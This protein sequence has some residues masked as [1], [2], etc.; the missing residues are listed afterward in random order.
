MPGT[1][2][3]VSDINTA[4]ALGVLLQVGRGAGSFEVFVSA[5]STVWCHGSSLDA[6]HLE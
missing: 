4:T 1:I 2:S 5:D 6:S 3:P